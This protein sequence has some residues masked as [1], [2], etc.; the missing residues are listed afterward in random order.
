M[1]AACGG[2]GGSAGTGNT[3]LPAAGSFPVQTAL[4]YAFT[5]GLQKNFNVTGAA[6]SGSN[7]L[8]ITGSLTFSSGTAIGTTFNGATAQQVTQTL[9]GSL[10]IAGQSVPLSS[11]SDVL[12]NASYA[13]LGSTGSGAGSNDYCVVTSGGAFP[14]TVSAG[15]T[16]SISTYACY[17]DSGKTAPTG[18]VTETYV[19]RAGSAANTLDLQI[20]DTVYDTSNKQ[21]DTQ[22]TTYNV[23]SAGV[24]SVTQVNVEGTQNGVTV[25]ITGQ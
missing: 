7:T 11:T 8:P 5:H 16:G 2:G 3:A 15:Q 4:T 21:V 14:A 17:T 25:T 6:A 9:T 13:E 23:T 18:S 24:P 19:A 20:I 1:L 10:S 12:L 22:S